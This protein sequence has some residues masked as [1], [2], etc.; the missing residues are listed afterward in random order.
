MKC[1]VDKT[2]LI[3]VEHER[4]E[5]DHCLKCSGIWFDSGE[6]ELLV[7]MLKAGGVGAQTDLLIPQEVKADEAQR[8]CP[9]CGRKMR[10]VCLGDG[11]SVLVDS[12]P[13]GDGL[14]FD[15]GE[16]QQVLADV[17]AA[18]TSVSKDIISFLGNAFESTHQA[19]R[20]K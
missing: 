7:S 18:D 20:K 15:A 14:W 2:D 6:L 12:C 9:V 10:K 5:L 16:L 1:L 8:K 4:I 17:K 13:Q 3:I 11:R 19:G